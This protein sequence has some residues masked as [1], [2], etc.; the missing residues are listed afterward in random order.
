M[1]SC[2]KIDLC[3]IKLSNVKILC[4]KAIVCLVTIVKW[5]MSSRV[6]LGKDISNC[7]GF[8]DSYCLKPAASTVEKINLLTVFNLCH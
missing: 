7:P 3:L 8:K 6:C 1:Q 2:F 5:G 4:L